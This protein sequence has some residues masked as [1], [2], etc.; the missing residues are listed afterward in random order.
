V[1]GERRKEK[2]ERWKEKG[3]SRKVKGGATG[4]VAR[5]SEGALKM[6]ECRDAGI[7]NA[8]M[9]EYWM[10]ERKGI[11]DGRKGD[12]KGRPYNQMTATVPTYLI[13]CMGLPS[14]R[15]TRSRHSR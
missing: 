4:P 5:A 7:Q 6:Q 13:T 14:I 8:G 11:L 12:R 3:E 1:R 2:G 9:K 10:E 15:V